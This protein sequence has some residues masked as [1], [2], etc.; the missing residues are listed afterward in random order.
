MNTTIIDHISINDIFWVQF[1]PYLV[2]FGFKGLPK[3]THLTI[4]FDD[5]E[6]DINLHVTKNADNPSDKPKI[7]IVCMDKTLLE[8]VAPSL[9]LAVLNKMLQPINLDDLKSKYDYDLGFIS[10]DSLQQSVTYSLTEQKLIDSFKDIS[11]FR[12][13]TRLKIDGDIEKRLESLA[14]SEH[15]QAAI[16]NNMAK[17]S[18][19]FQTPI[20]GGM[21]ISDENTLQVIRIN[22]KWFTIHTDLKP[23]DL[24]TAFINPK[25]ARHLIWKTMRAIIAVKNAKRYVDTEHLDKPIR[26]VKIQAKETNAPT[27]Q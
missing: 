1:R 25:L 4:V 20:E 2:S 13:K 17:L 9:S 26:L 14:T 24:L 12:K 10:F 22:D 23:S 16:F 11:R 5:K 21:I 18:T 7:G 6:P 15:L 19:G 27:Q 8:E 3:D